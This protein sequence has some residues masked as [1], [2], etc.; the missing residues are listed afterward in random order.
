MAL[1]L[2]NKWRWSLGM[3]FW[4]WLL[5][6]GVFSKPFF[7]VS[8]G[9][10]LEVFFRMDTIQIGNMS[11]SRH[12]YSLG[13]MIEIVAIALVVSVVGIVIGLAEKRTVQKVRDRQAQLRLRIHASP[14]PFHDFTI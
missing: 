3:R 13:D 4:L 1:D 11:V 5:N 6:C 14:S 8:A 9:T 10:F 12:H 2:R 7:I